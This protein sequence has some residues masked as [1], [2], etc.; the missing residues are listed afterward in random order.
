[1][2]NLEKKVRN[3]Q[4]LEIKELNQSGKL[5]ATYIHTIS[6][7]EKRCRVDIDIPKGTSTWVMSIVEAFMPVG[8]PDSVTHDYTP[9]QFYDSIQAFASTIAGLLSS[10][11][12]LQG[13][14]VG[15]STASATGAVLLSVLQESAGRI[16]TILFAHR[17]GS[18]LEPEC[19]KYRLMADIFNDTAML[20]DCVS[21]AFPKVPPGS[22][23]ASL[24]AHFAKQGNL[25][26]LNAKDA[27]QETLIS[28]LGMLVGT[29]V[30]S[31]ISSQTATW[32]ALITLLSIHLGTNYLAVRSVTMRT[33]NRQRANLVLSP[34]LY[35][36]TSDN[37][38]NTSR[39]V[40]RRT[41]KLQHP[42]HL[43]HPPTELP[44]FPPQKTSA[45]KNASSKATA[46][47]VS[48]LRAKSSP[49][50]KSAP[51]SPR[52][53]P[54]SPAPKTRAATTHPP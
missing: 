23:K 43:P 6:D 2:P 42:A 34:F 10:R 32:I 25:A 27:S 15:D 31:K 4:Q 19:K 38:R 37:K 40:T 21:P 33:L 52:S 16:A 36:V 45:S 3:D 5:I 14:G 1:M 44:P 28:L 18:A 35:S 24:S 7:D 26:E 47:S 22:S 11:A 41:K 20:L 49:T 30:V 17:L 53:S 13:L 54:P 46:Q 29:F 51:A 39:P 48:S 12:V 50:A 8:Y 9:Y